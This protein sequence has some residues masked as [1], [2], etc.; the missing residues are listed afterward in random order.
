MRKWPT[1]FLE[2]EEKKKS[3]NEQAAKTKTAQGSQL[4]GSPK[5]WIPKTFFKC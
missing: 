1:A 5:K 4:Y 2:M 3:G